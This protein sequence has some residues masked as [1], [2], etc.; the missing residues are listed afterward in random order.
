[1]FFFVDERYKRMMAHGAYLVIRWKMRKCN[2]RG[3]GELIFYA[4]SKDGT[5]SAIADRMLPPAIVMNATNK[6]ETIAE[7]TQCPPTA[8]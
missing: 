8:S 4:H 7:G 3:D 2:L 1:L 5:G 6:A